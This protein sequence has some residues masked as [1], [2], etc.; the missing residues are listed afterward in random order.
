M[1]ILGLL[2]IT[3]DVAPSAALGVLC[4]RKNWWP[5]TVFLGD[6]TVDGTNPANQLIWKMSHDLR[7]VLYI[8]GGW[9]DF[10]HQQYDSQEL[11]HDAKQVYKKTSP[12]SIKCASPNPG[13]HHHEK[14]IKERSSFLPASHELLHQ[15]FDLNSMVSV[16]T[17]GVQPW[18]VRQNWQT[19]PVELPSQSL[20][21]GSWKWCF[22][23]S[24]SPNFQGWKIFRWTM[25]DF[26]GDFHIPP[27]G[28]KEKSST[29]KCRL[30][31]D[32]SSAG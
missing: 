23:S 8:P 21:A 7:R 3:W 5:S 1:S 25:F 28:E 14:G 15:K 31:E 29:Q 32:I 19:L 16:G 13:D 17:A 11:D 22:P 9:R 30:V 26:R 6:N 12:C 4:G 24:E 2:A 18:S 27:N 20:T 10:F